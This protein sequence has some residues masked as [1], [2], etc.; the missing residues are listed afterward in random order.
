MWYRSSWSHRCLRWEINW[1][2]WSIES[3]WLI[4]QRILCKRRYNNLDFNYNKPIASFNNNLCF[5]HKVSNKTKSHQ[6]SMCN[7]LGRIM[8]E[9]PIQVWMIPTQPIVENQQFLIFHPV[10][11]TIE[12][13]LPIEEESHLPIMTSLCQW[14]KLMKDTISLKVITWGLYCNGMISL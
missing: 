4:P 9:V 11:I 8:I 14:S 2:K 12:S 3:S 6:F 7:Q 13:L 10:A 5:S 1:E